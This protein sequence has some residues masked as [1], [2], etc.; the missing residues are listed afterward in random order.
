[1]KN[2]YIIEKI[3]NKGVHGKI[4]LCHAIPCN[5]LCKNQI[6]QENITS[7]IKY[8]SEL[9]VLKIIYALRTHNYKDQSK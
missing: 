5:D 4:Q 2:K 6:I 8:I 1:M 3:L 9:V 7:N